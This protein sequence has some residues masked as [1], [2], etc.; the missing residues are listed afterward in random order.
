MESS[1]GDVLLNV[2]VERAVYRGAVKSCL[3]IGATSSK[4]LSES[5]CAKA[6]HGSLLV[7]STP[8][9][10]SSLMDLWTEGMCLTFGVW[11]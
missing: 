1:C 11:K 3:S 8:V 7:L 4:A 9:P 2:A 5:S 6:E 10:S